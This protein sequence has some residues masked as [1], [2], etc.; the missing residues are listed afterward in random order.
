MTDP[1]V[2]LERYR[3]DI[4]HWSRILCGDIVGPHGS[5]A[6]QDVA[7]ML[8]TDLRRYADYLDNCREGHVAG[9]IVFPSWDD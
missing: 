9:P 6:W 2:I 1:F 8:A 3:N 4:R 7:A 5:R